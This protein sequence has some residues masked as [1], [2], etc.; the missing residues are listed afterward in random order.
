VGPALIAR[1][2]SE[3]EDGARVNANDIITYTLELTNAGELNAVNVL[4]RAETPA[5]TNLV[6]GTAG[7][8]APGALLGMLE[9]G[10]IVT[11]II[12]QLGIGET[13][14]FTFQVRVEDMESMGSRA[15]IGSAEVAETTPGGDPAA[16]L[17]TS[18]YFVSANKVRHIQMVGASIVVHKVDAATGE[19]LADAEFTL[20]ALSVADP[21]LDFDTMDAVSGEDGE[22]VFDGVPIGRYEI[23]ETEA[24]E[25]YQLN[26]IR[27]SVNIDGTQ[28]QRE[29]TISNTL[30]EELEGYMTPNVGSGSRTEGDSP[31]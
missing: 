26:P 5:F 22:V 28:R 9:N 10:R 12:P 16:E 21:D 6:G 19:P 14:I 24:P 31:T 4:V 3:P 29:V 15:L 18:P 23:F 7:T 13:R 17:L 20:R 1:F 11:W 8:D 2:T 25:G 27:R 30:G